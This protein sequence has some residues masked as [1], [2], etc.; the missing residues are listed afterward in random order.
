MSSRAIG[1]SH[2]EPHR[3]S[4]SQRQSDV[5][6]ATNHESFESLLTHYTSTLLPTDLVFDSTLAWRIE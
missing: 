5:N 6:K 3:F 4:H 2:A 1:P